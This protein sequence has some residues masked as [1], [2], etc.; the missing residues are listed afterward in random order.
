MKAKKFNIYHPLHGM[1]NNWCLMEGF[2][3]E[4]IGTVHADCVQNSF[5]MSQNHNSE[6]AQLGRRSTSVGDIICD[7]TS[8]YIVL[9][10]NLFPIRE[11]I[12]LYKRI[13]DMNK[14]ISYPVNDNNIED[15][16][17]GI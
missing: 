14:I 8:V 17:D 1:I 10:D 3:Y 13:M 16:I 4:Y 9:G 11:Q 2:S 12:P 5:A 6:Y 7:N 15:L